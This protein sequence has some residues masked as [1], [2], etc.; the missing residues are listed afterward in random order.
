MVVGRV[1]DTENTGEV[2]Q[3]C[4]VVDGDL[5]TAALVMVVTKADFEVASVTEI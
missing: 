5:L 1:S 2:T 4:P 3:V